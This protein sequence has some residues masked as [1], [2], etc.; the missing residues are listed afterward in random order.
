MARVLTIGMLMT[1]AAAEGFY[2][3]DYPVERHFSFP[4]QDPKNGKPTSSWE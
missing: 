1:L 2:A 3:H 4:D